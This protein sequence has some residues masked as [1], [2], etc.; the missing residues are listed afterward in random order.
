[1]NGSALLQIAV[2]LLK[3]HTEFH[4]CME[5]ALWKF[6]LA[7]W[8][9][10]NI[11][12]LYLSVNK[13]SEKKSSLFI[14]DITKLRCSF[15][16]CSVL[17]L[18]LRLLIGWREETLERR[19]YRVT[20]KDFWCHDLVMAGCRVKN[21]WVAFLSFPNYCSSL[22]RVSRDNEHKKDVPKTKLCYY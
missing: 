1:M 4:P 10:F 3:Y 12:C 15:S 7:W 16:T 8:K 19:H 22:V 2:W 5:S 18:F 11:Y 17:Y 21:E 20:N 13:K 6:D 14:R 9:L